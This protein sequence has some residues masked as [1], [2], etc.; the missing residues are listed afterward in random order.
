[1]FR[2]FVNPRKV[3]PP[4]G[5]NMIDQSELHPSTLSALLE[6]AWNHRVA[7]SGL[8]A[9]HPQ[10]R[11]EI[12]GLPNQY[13][14]P[15]LNIQV[16]RMAPATGS[17]D[18]AA[19][20]TEIQQFSTTT[21]TGPDTVTIRGIRWPHL[22]YAY[23]IENTRI[24]EVF[25]RLVDSCV[26]GEKLGVLSPVSQR[27]L[28]TTEELFFRD[29]PSYS[30]N[31]QTSY[32]RPNL[33]ATRANAYQRM[34]G[35]TLNAADASNPAFA[36]A[37]HANADFVAVLDELLHEVWQGRTNFANAAGARPTDDAKIAE[38]ATRLGEMMRARR[39][40]GTLSREEFFAVSTMQWFHETLETANHPLLIDLRS[41]AP[42]PEERL[43]KIAQR[44][45]YPAHGLAKSYFEIAE[46]LS[47]LLIGVEEGTYNNPLAVPALY[48][49]SPPAPDGGPAADLDLIM[50]HWSIIRGRDVKAKKVAA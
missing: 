11:S 7:E 24:V 36:V 31:T 39:I 8:N 30:I 22:I 33:A 16:P 10:R 28:W 21:G 15:L 43:F 26:H 25:R 34:F 50:T 40:N 9:G 27:W 42:S 19:L 14:N 41:E 37:E 18:V 29:P 47:R 32:I 20:D 4:V 23:M 5:I 44:V 17:I 1:M 2:F 3:Q 45:N 13:L 6:R 46:P 35:M 48:T 38:R 12:P 49:P